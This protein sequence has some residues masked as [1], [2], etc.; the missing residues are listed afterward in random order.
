MIRKDTADKIYKTKAGKLKAIIR[1]IAEKHRHD[2][3]VLVGTVSIEKNELLSAMLTHEGIPHNILNA[4]NHEKE[5]EIISQAGRPGAVTVATNMAGRGVDII[6]GGNPFE[7]DLQSKA[8]EAGGLHVIGTERH[9]A[10]R[11][12][13]QLRGRAGRQGDSGS[14][15]FYV[16]MED[17]LV[18]VFGGDRLKSLMDRLGVGE[19]DVIE[20]RFVSR[21]IEQAQS[22]IEGHNF[23]IRKYVLEYDD[24][25]N[26][27][28]DAVYR[29][30]RE[31]LFSDSNKNLVLEWVANYIEDGEAQY[32]AKEQKIGPDMMKQLERFILLR[33][34]DQVWLDH[35]EA[36]EYLR[37]SV[38]LRAYGQRDP[39]I[40]YKIEAQNM[41][42]QLLET[43]KARVADLIF[44]AEI[45]QKP[46]R[47]KNI[48]ES[49]PD[50]LR[51]SSHK[52]QEVVNE[53]RLRSS[54]S[55]IQ[56][57]QAVFEPSGPKIGRNE[58]CWCGAINPK[59]GKVYKYKICH[60]K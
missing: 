48:Q 17:E 2:Q 4:K 19:D 44:K 46:E 15:S 28:R 9:E 18:R 52:H 47:L 22:R 35:I 14:S 58:P 42:Q 41:F 29:V 31:I 25:M 1:E 20:N 26:K 51:E 39:L 12:D 6:L 53:P 49:R 54:S 43:M 36:M 27:H 21:A 56:E 8:K 40:E 50:V 11:I 59:T 57:R 33:V 55:E 60:G 3:P 37:D 7:S 5:A 24:V 16:S 30:R 13:D 10:R 45:V 34:I 38:R 32:T 23:D